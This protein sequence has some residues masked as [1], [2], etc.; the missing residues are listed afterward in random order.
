[1][2]KILF[3]YY[4]FQKDGDSTEQIKQRVLHEEPDF[5]LFEKQS[6][7]VKKQLLPFVNL[8][9]LLLRKEP[10]SRLHDF[11]RVRG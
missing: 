7:N 5:W 4:P 10:K 1:L 2:F 8:I 9:R 3:G 11:E 6:N